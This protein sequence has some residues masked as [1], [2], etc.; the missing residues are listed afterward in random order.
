ME[1]MVN[2][3]RATQAD[4]AVL[5]DI[6][7]RAFGAVNAKHG[8][9]PELPTPDIAQGLIGFMLSDPQNIFGVVAEV[10]GKVIG[11][12][13][14][15]TG[16]TIA[17]I[18]PINVDPDSQAKQVGRKLMQACIDH[19]RELRKPGVRLVQAAFNTISMSLYTKLGFDIREPLVVIQGTPLK[20]SIPGFNVRA[21]TSDDIDACDT[22][23]RDVHGHTRTGELHGAIAQKTGQVVEVNGQ[24]TG[25]TTGVAFFAHT[26]A[27]SNSDLIALISA[28]EAFSGPGFLLPSRNG[29][30]FRWCL[31]NGLR[32]VEP[33]SLMSMG[34]YNKPKG[35]FLPSILF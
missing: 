28:A 10:N 8:F 25:Y 2:I 26:V 6:C 22:L 9:P 33:M 16:D 19:A 12:N 29:E 18:G 31:A 32:V 3:R 14:M 20:K 17:G 24:I 30:V 13:F 23:C 4:H 21:M 27:R 1:A 5:S 7:F 15:S 11:N 35:A 34:L